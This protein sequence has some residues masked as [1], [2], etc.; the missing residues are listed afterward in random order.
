[1]PLEKIGTI[2]IGA[3]NSGP[4]ELASLKLTFSGNGYAA[5]GAN[6]LNTISLRD[7]NA[8]DVATSFGAAETKDV[9]AGTIAW[10][11]PTSASDLPVISPGTQLTLQLWAETDVIPGA[12]GTAESLSVTVQNPS[13]LTFY[14]GSDPAAISMGP[15]PLSVTETPFT[16]TSLSWGVGM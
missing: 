5:G 9:N 7:P 8:V 6:F 2:T 13:D 1:M 11:F 16:V 15:L 3:S 12:S 14:D 10:T 4:I